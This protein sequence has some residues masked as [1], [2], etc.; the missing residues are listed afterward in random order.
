[1]QIMNEFLNIYPKIFFVKKKTGGFFYL[2][3]KKYR[4]SLLK[5]AATGGSKQC[6]NDTVFF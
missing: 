4:N 3:G 2:K 5:Y 1:M 6:Y